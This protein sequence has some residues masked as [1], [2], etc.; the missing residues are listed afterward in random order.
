VPAI[1]DAHPMRIQIAKLE[2]VAQ[3][4]H[5]VTLAALATHVFVHYGVT[6]PPENKAI[7]SSKLH[8]PD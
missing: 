6:A 7:S 4:R 5:K 2:S 1:L 3:A 8:S